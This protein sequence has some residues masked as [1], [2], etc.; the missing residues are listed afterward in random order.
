MK[1]FVLGVAVGAIGMGL[2]TGSIKVTVPHKD[3]ENITYKGMSGE[4]S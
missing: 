3:E 4:P 2:Y 1:N